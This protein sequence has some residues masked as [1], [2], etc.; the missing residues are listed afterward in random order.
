MLS[1]RIFA[2]PITI[3]SLLFHRYS[4]GVGSRGSI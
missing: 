3:L 1:E 4:S 2:M